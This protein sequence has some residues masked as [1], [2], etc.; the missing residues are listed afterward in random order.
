MNRTKDTTSTIPE[1]LVLGGIPR[2]GTKLLR[3]TLGSH[4]QIRLMPREQRSLQFYDLSVALH[5]AVLGAASTGWQAFRDPAQRRLMLRY[6]RHLLA[7]HRWREPTSLDMIHQ[8]LVAALAQPNTQYVG[9]KYPDYLL[10]YP[11]YVHRPRTRCVFIYRDPRD[12]VASMTIRV[13]YGSWGR[14]PWSTKF[15]TVAKATAY[16]LLGMQCIEDISRLDTNALAIRYEDFVTDPKSTVA[17]LANHLAVPAADFNWSE[18]HVKG[19]GKYRETLNEGEIATVSRLAGAFMQ[20]H[21][22][23]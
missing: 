6:A 1:L 18:V 16:W 7:H 3:R 4:P 12:V 14:R 17:A 10:H 19:I 8:A 2:A 5:L 20:R 9:D 22:Y 11:R 21:N 13:R 23:L 15:D